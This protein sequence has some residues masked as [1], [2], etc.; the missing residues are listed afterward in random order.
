MSA[1][2]T[3]LAQTFHSPHWSVDEL[4]SLEGKNIIVTGSTAGLGKETC[5]QLGKK[6]ANIYCVGRNA[7]KLEELVVELKKECQNDNI[8]FLVA[9]MMDLVSV[10]KA[11][12]EFLSKNIQ[13]DVLVNNAGIMHAPWSL[14]KQGIESQFATNHFAT[15]VLTM[16]L[17]PA[18]ADRS[19]IVTL[20]SIA[21]YS[22]IPSGGIAY[23]KLNDELNY[24]NNSRYSETKLANIHFTK[25][26][27]QLLNENGKNVFVNCVHPG[28]VKTGLFANSPWYVKLID[29]FFINTQRGA[30]TQIFVAADKSIETNNYKGEYF[31]TYCTKDTPSEYALND[32]MIKATASWTESILKKQFRSDWSFSINR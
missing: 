20:S 14:S 29:G 17:L 15:T 22:A 25:Y 2:R 19:R 9:D 23:D 13:L 3:L 26:L 16:K 12:D 24:D 31:A 18:L 28:V 30:L 32:S 11:A 4:P 8:H 1:R 27:Q 6:K 7:T 10:E 5:L 21:H